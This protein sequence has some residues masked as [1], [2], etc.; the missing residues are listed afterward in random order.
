MLFNR[1][2][3]FCKNFFISFKAFLRNKVVTFVTINIYI[4]TLNK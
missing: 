2:T 1:I 4:Y 3:A